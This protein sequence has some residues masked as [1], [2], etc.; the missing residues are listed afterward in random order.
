MTIR[1][2]IAQQALALPPE[3]RAFLAELLE[4]SLTADGFTTPE[5]EAEWAAEVARRIE[6]YDRG[7]THAV[8]AVTAMREMREGLAN[9]RTG[10]GK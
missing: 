8:D 10:T 1:E 7:E 4:N 3:D 6:A 9:S 5:L 2:Q